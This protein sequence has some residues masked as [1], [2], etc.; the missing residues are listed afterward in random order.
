MTLSASAYVAEK[1]LTA[2]FLHGAAKESLQAT[3]N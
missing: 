2:S 3:F 1:E